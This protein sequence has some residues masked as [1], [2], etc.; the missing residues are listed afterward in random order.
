MYVNETYALTAIFILVAALVL[1]AMTNAWWEQDREDCKPFIWGFTFGWLLVISGVIT[2]LRPNLPFHAAADLALFTPG[3]TQRLTT[4]ELVRGWMLVASGLAALFRWPLG[5]IVATVLFGNPLIWIVNW[6]Y[7]RKRWTELTTLNLY[8]VHEVDSSESHAGHSDWVK[9][10]RRYRANGDQGDAPVFRSPPLRTLLDWLY[11][12]RSR[13]QRQV[14][15]VLFAWAVIVTVGG[16]L[17]S[18]RRGVDWQ[19]IALWIALPP[20]ALW[21]LLKVYWA[22]EGLIQSPDDADASQSAP[23]Q[24]QPAIEDRRRHPN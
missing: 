24:P 6:F 7:Y 5:V 18:D 10:A 12:K 8:A 13:R 4:Y 15:F 9:S 3:G 20:A 16:V 11:V 19:D 21:L 22:L 23:P 1:G 14:R 17:L 2:L